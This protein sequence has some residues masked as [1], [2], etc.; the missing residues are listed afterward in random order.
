MLF[1]FLNKSFIVSLNGGFKLV[2]WNNQL[3]A[4]S[5][6]Y[7]H[8]NDTPSYSLLTTKKYT[9]SVVK[10]SYKPVLLLSRNRLIKHS[11]NRSKEGVRV[12][13]QCLLWPKATTIAM[14]NLQM[15]LDDQMLHSHFMKSHWLCSCQRSHKPL[16]DK[17][18][19]ERGIKRGRGLAMFT[20][21]I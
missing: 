13:V 7:W 15:L 20:N 10:G 16:L 5:K 14:K 21:W 19:W 3:H 4:R 17:W 11:K 2:K 6:A 1:L 9:G 12:T 8:A 18:E